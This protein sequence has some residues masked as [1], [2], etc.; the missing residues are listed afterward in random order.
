[1]RALL[2]YNAVAELLNEVEELTLIEYNHVV[3]LLSA[4]L[5]HRDGASQEIWDATEHAAGIM[6]TEV[7][8]VDAGVLPNEDGLHHDGSTIQLDM[9]DPDERPTV[10]VYKGKADDRYNMDRY[11]TGVL[12]KFHEVAMYSVE[13]VIEHEE[14]TGTPVISEIRYGHT[15]G[16]FTIIMNRDL[17]SILTLFGGFKLTDFLPVNVEVITTN[18]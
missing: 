18:Q 10:I 6:G 11:N 5:P 14:E 4:Q 13:D 2:I 16:G 15:S 8:H 9:P 1:M 17:S 12:F 7:V 3:R